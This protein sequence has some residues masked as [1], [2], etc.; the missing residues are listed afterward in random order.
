[1]AALSVMAYFV[2]LGLAV[3]VPVWLVAHVV[4]RDDRRVTPRRRDEVS[5]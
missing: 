2:G 3:V 4:W 5:R 1:M